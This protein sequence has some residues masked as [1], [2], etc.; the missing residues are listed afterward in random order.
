METIRG[1]LD[2]MT[3]LEA[4]ENQNL[5]AVTTAIE[6]GADVNETLI[7]AV[8]LGNPKIVEKLLQAGSQVDTAEPISGNSALHTAVLHAFNTEIVELLLNAKAD[9]NAKNKLGNSAL[10][11][12]VERADFEMVKFLVDSGADVNA[13][14]S[15]GR[16]ALHLA[17][18]GHYNEMLKFL[19]DRGA[20]VGVKD[21]EGK[22]PWDWACQF[23]NFEGEEILRALQR[24]VQAND[25]LVF[26][27]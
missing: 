16:T 3:L 18:A 8:Q 23:D 13:R 17:A 12:A 5:D 2:K 26:K 9:V 19:L 15:L 22:T 10:H 25:N 14:N 21:E 7:L 11:C 4:V 1:S 6:E 27:F 20:K 24:G